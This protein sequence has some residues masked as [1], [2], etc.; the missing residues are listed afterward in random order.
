MVSIVALQLL[1]TAAAAAASA[2]DDESDG[3]AAAG[4]EYVVHV[5]QQ[6]RPP[7]AVAAD[8]DGSASAPFPTIHAARDH[9]R[10]LR[11]RDDSEVGGALAS[12]RSYR[13]TSARGRTRRCGWS[14]TTPGAPGGRSST[15]PTDRMVLPSYRPASR[16]PRPRSGRTPAGTPA[17]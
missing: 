8:P 15:K 17:S 2:H 6:R 10:A 14:R 1:L 5:R 13:V 7:T 3:D 9:L 16:S 12:Q 11:L 4:A